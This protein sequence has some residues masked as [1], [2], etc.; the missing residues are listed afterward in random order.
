LPAVSLECTV[1]D[2]YS[3]QDS[4]K[5]IESLVSST[6]GGTGISVD[7]RGEKETITK[8]LGG[9]AEAALYALAAI[10]IIL[11]IQFKSSRQTLII[12]LTIPL[13]IIGSMAGLYIFRQPF[14]FTAG[15]GLAS[16]I[17]IVVNNAILL[18]EH[19]N[20][21]IKEGDSVMDSCISSLNRRFRPI[22][23]STIT[24]IMGL[25]P[26]ALSGSSFF[27]PMAVTLMSGLFVSTFFTLIVIPT[28][29]N[30]IF[31]RAK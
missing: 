11:L 21:A 26:L 6:I 9:I 14:S 24:T 8:Y 15:L 4:Q 23:L 22:M 5:Y 18:L 3:V 10:Y 17:G 19:I 13:S 31:N 16:L 29:Y 25:F 28:M 12:L 27:T 20:N 1:R 30:S 2:G 7:Y